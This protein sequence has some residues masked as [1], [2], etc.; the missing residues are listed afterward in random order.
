[1]ERG[2]FSNAFTSLESTEK[3][4]FV[5][6]LLD[7]ILDDRSTCAVSEELNE[8]NVCGSKLGKFNS[9]FEEGSES[10]QARIDQLLHLFALQTTDEVLLV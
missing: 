7:D 10:G 6:T 5:E 2:S 8:M 3:L 4:S 9:L 1:L